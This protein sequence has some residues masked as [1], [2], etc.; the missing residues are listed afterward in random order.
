[1][2]AH[3]VPVSTRYDDLFDTCGTGGDRS[4]TFNISSCAALVVAACGVKVAKHGNRSASSNV[5]GA[6]VYEALGV[7]ITASP[8]I[9]ERCL[10]DAG[11]GFFFAP[12]FHPSMRHAAP[13]RRELGIR[14][15][16]NLLGPLTNPAGATRQLVGVPKPEFTELMARALLLLGTTRA[17][18][19]HG[20]DGIDELTTTGYT[21]I[22]E[23]RN[24]AVN[25][26]YLHPAE[27]GLSKASDGSLL[28]GDARANAR[29]IER[30]LD[31]ARGPARD[32]VLLNAGAALF[33]AG[34]AASVTEGILMASR[35]I[36]GGDAKR[37]LE[38]LVSISTAEELV[39]GASA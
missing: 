38:R 32:V 20:A 23:C 29:I 7:R 34:A 11:I 28:G 21:K 12:T 6:D 8:A 30:V 13:V 26:F 10:A 9:V 16:F 15:A 33:I 35:A 24:G 25:T 22:S 1:M 3:A 2:R 37:T 17:W 14:T 18:V 31:G 39:T 5:G 19:V 36:D 4:G 27:V